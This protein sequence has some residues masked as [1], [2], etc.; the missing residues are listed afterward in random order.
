MTAYEQI[1][2]VMQGKN[3]MVVTSAFIK[4]EVNKRFR[5]DIDSVIPSDFC[6]NRTNNGIRFS[7][8]NR[9]FEYLGKGAYKY[10]GEKYPYS[11]KVYHKPQ[12]SKSENVV[13]SWVNGNLKFPLQ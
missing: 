4:N 7:E 12:R 9:L 1:R 5:V 6:Y 8:D 3:G 11:G 13:G 2:E 10:L